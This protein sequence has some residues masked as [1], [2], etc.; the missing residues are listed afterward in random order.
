MAN[1][2]WLY[3]YEETAVLYIYVYTYIIV[4]N[5]TAFKAKSYAVRNT[6]VFV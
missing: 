4:F 3:V 6:E 5:T 2:N 1:C